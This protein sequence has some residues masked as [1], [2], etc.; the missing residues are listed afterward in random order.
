VTVR[1]ARHQ[2]SIVQLTLKVIMMGTSVSA[3]NGLDPQL[4]RQLLDSMQKDHQASLDA[5]EHDHD[6]SNKMVADIT[7]SAM[8]SMTRMMT[9]MSESLQASMRYSAMQS[10]DYFNSMSRIVPQLQ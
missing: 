2:S 7:N 6:S 9:S 3:Q 10:G 4:S 5:I 1:T 8:S